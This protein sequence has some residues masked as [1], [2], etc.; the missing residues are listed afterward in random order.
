MGIIS[1]EI[2]TSR[3]ANARRGLGRCCFNALSEWGKDGQD[4]NGQGRIFSSFP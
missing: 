2:K 3:P 4:K 1:T